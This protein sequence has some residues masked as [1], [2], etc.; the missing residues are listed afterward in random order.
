MASPDP[1]ALTPEAKLQEMK[2]LLK[3]RERRYVIQLADGLLFAHLAD[4][5][6]NQWKS[7]VAAT[8][9]PIV[10]YFNVPIDEVER[11]TLLDKIGAVRRIQEQISW[12][13]A[14]TEVA[15]QFRTTTTSK[16]YTA[17]TLRSN[18]KL[19][20]QK[21]KA[22]EWSV[23]RAKECTPAEFVS[24]VTRFAT[25]TLQYDLRGHRPRSSAAHLATPRLPVASGVS[26]D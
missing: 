14:A 9:K 19:Q 25:R 4:D 17:S 10:E 18:I 26:F 5:S 7:I 23:A 2:A 11:T 6:K 1:A 22:K 8:K 3:K 24:E 12:A 13:R 15:E 16:P 21:P 20:A